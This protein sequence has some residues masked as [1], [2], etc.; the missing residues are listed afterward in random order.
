[1]LSGGRYPLREGDWRRNATTQTAPVRLAKAAAEDALAQSQAIEGI[2]LMSEQHQNRRSAAQRLSELEA[3]AAEARAER[4]EAEARATSAVQQHAAAQ[5]QVSC[6]EAELS[7]RAVALALCR[8]SFSAKEAELD[9]VLN[10]VQ[11]RR[12]EARSQ[13]D[14][15]DSPTQTLVNVRPQ[16]L[17]RELRELEKQL[18]SRD[19]QIARLLSELRFAKL[20][21]S[22]PSTAVPSRLTSTASATSSAGTSFGHDFRRAG[23]EP[24]VVRTLSQTC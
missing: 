7:A 24:Q 9:R 17:E 18:E 6:L 21:D 11:E 16:D 2:Q 15:G 20:K 22:V 12:A 4:S 13:G 8:H 10:R 19:E 5:R 14:Q 3:A 1:M 23:L